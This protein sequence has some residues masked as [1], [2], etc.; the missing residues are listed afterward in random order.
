MVPMQVPVLGLWQVAWHVTCVVLAAVC[1]LHSW[2]VVRQDALPL[3]RAWAALTSALRR[4]ASPSQ[5]A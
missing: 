2:A 3:Q 5:P 1:A 4:Q